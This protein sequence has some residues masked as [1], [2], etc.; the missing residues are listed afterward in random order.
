MTCYLQQV[1]FLKENNVFFFNFCD[2]YS[3]PPVTRNFMMKTK[4]FLHF[5]LDFPDNTIIA[6]RF[7][8]NLNLFQHCL[9][10]EALML[11]LS[12]ATW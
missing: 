11:F 7:K 10:L 9:P 5:S 8:N 2:Y 3:R 1:K 4:M 12:V 6:H